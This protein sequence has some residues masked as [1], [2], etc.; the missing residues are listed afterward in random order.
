[1]YL[2]AAGLWWI[3]ERHLGGS[4]AANKIFILETFFIRSGLKL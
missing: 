4:A 2:K 3:S 1:M